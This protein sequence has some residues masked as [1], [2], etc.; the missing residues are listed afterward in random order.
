MTA[1][2]TAGTRFAPG[3]EVD[4]FVLGQKIHTGAMALIYRLAGPNGLLPLVMKIP[5]LGPGEA[6]ANVVSFEVERMILGALFS[7]HVPTLVAMGDVETTPYLV[8]EFVDG[9]LLGAWAGRAPLPAQEV[10]RLGAA[11]ALAL[12]ELC[13]RDVVHLDLKPAN[14]LFR[15]TGEAVLIDFGLAHHAHFPDLLAEEFRH[16]VGNWP[17]MSPEQVLGVRCDPRSDLF[18]LGVILYELA[19]ARLPFGTP[20]SVAGLRKR[21]YAEPPPPRAVVAATPEWLQEIILRCLEVDARDRY[22]AASEVAFDLLHPDQV[23]VTSRGTRQGKRGWAGRVR[24]WV[25]AAGFE[26]APCPPAMTATSPAPI[27]L[28]ALLSTH[29]PLAPAIRDAVN[30]LLGV[31]PRCRIA[32]ITVIRPEPALGAEKFE[33]SAT[34]LYIRNLVA[35]REWAKPLNLPDER[36]TCH[37]IESDKPGRALLDYASYNDVEQIFV[38]A[39]E[40]AADTRSTL[41]S[42]AAKVVGE[43]PCSVTVVRG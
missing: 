18:A 3:R 35:L 43:A 39:S 32:C 24:R 21:L 20:T 26:A 15:A 41:G 8:M 30:R 29:S 33:D 40:G 28:V 36:L 7:R 1:A 4:G 14:V 6:G 34:S 13:L 10:A 11:I 23:Q 22:A 25:R 38:G 42:V 37:V 9:P 2:T 5:R 12:H 27:V 16:P 19:T 31:H 17:Y